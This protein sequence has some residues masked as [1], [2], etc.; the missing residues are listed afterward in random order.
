MTKKLREHYVL[1]F[2]FCLMLV[3]FTDKDA[4]ATPIKL[5]LAHEQPQDHPY[6]YGAV[7]FA[8]LVKE[9]SN[10]EMEIEIFINGTMGKASALAESVSMGT[11][12]FASIFSIILEAY[13]PEF[14]ALTLPYC[15]SSWEHCFKVL[16]GPIGD[17][18]KATVE[19]KGIKVLTFWT[20]GLAQV[21]SNILIRTPD[22]LRGKKLRIQEGPSYAALSNVLGA[23]TTPMSFG[24][25]Y[26]ALQ[27]KTIDAQMQT[28]N[29]IFYSKFY[30]VAPHFTKI[31]MNFNTQPFI[32]SM[33]TWNSLSAEHREII[34]KAA[35]EAAIRERAY[36]AEDTQKCLDQTAANGGNI[37]ELSAEEMQQWRGV[38]QKVYEDPQFAGIMGIFNRIQ[39]E[40]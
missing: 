33:Q 9:Y 30:E 12:D 40:K 38:C 22:E 31:D 18:L 23:V 28:I 35:N 1:V 34:Q 19:P 7:Q 6:H 11:M 17:E 2:V 15:F 16:D 29:N 8:E 13:A 21:N 14:G 4:I 27:L 20:N 36:H 32:M 10:G 3:I 39:T 24:E 26:S 37:I 5:Q 25:V